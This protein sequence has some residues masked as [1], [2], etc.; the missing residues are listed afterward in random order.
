[1]ARAPSNPTPA[2][3]LRP[4]KGWRPY[5][6]GRLAFSLGAP[7]EPP[8]SYSTGPAAAWKQGWTDARDRRAQSKEV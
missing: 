3:R 8:G 1:M 4:L 7:C 6:L 2:A 5:D